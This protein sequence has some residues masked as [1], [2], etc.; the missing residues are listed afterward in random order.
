MDNTRLN[1]LC[2]LRERINTEIDAILRTQNRQ[3]TLR[4]MRQRHR[5]RAE[6]DLTRRSDGHRRRAV[7]GTN[8]GYNRHR[9]LLREPACDACKEAHRDYIVLLKARKR[10]TEKGTKGG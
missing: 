5:Q 8:S 6:V 9:R 1:R 4:E 2:A 10:A 3:D 7:C